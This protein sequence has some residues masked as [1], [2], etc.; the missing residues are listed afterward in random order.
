[1]GSVILQTTLF[2]EATERRDESPDVPH[3]Q[4]AASAR[5]ESASKAPITRMVAS[6]GRIDA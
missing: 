6:S 5:D 1:M 3:D 2:A 4:S